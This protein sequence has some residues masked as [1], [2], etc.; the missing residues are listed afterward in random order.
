MF[1]WANLFSLPCMGPH[2]PHLSDRNIKRI[3]R[4]GNSFSNISTLCL[5]LM[6]SSCLEMASALDLLA[7]F[8]RQFFYCKWEFS[9]H[10]DIQSSIWGLTIVM[11]GGEKW[12][13]ENVT[14]VLWIRSA[15]SRPRDL[16]LGIR[17]RKPP[18]LLFI[19]ELWSRKMDDNKKRWLRNK[20][21]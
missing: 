16:F 4:R 15:F 3:I 1:S 18:F 6:L 5:A 21:N 10:H 9:L 20:E 2:C 13:G 19:A 14:N 8:H 7:G 11:Q 17:E 12:K